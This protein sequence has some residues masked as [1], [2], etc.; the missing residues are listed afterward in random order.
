MSCCSGDNR[1]NMRILLI[2]NNKVVAWM[3]SLL[4][5][6]NDFRSRVTKLFC[7]LYIH[8][9]FSWSSLQL[10]FVDSFGFMSQPSAELS[11][12]YL[13]RVMFSALLSAVAKST[14]FYFITTV[15][16]VCETL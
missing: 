9:K 15:F 13:Y 12:P 8:M 7:L 16:P 2:L 5:G 3:L 14:Y 11:V 1:P 6:Q 10:F 4:L